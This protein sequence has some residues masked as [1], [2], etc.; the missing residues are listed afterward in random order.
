VRQFT[1]LHPDRR[2]LLLT[3]R[4]ECGRRKFICT[5]LRPTQVRTGLWR[6]VRCDAQ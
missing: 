1:D 3:P 6:A 4:N 5:T 2:P